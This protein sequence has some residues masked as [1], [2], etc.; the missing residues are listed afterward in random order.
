MNEVVGIYG[1]P[2]R[3]KVKIRA[4]PENGK[5]ND[6]LIIYLSEIFQIKKGKI[7]ILRGHTNKRKDLIV[8][9]DYEYLYLQISECLKNLEFK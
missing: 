3:L 6:M 4:V 1:I 8:D 7:E 9:A 2:E 5:A